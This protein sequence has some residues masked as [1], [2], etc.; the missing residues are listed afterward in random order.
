[1]EVFM[2][3]VQTKLLIDPF[4]YE[5]AA[6]LSD[7][8]GKQTVEVYNRWLLQG[9]SVNGIAVPGG[10]LPVRKHYVYP[11]DK[12][13]WFAK[14]FTEEFFRHGLMQKGYYWVKAEDYTGPEGEIQK[15]IKYV[16]EAQ[17]NK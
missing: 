4:S 16:L 3:T 13:E 9:L 17:K 10:F 5:A 15:A 6:K 12:P 14:A 2:S 11:T 8:Q 1:M 7:E